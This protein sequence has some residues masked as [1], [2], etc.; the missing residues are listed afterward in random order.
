MR[1][2]GYQVAREWPD[3]SVAALTPLVMGTWRLLYGTREFVLDA[4]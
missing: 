1:E 3:G 4:W 2:Q